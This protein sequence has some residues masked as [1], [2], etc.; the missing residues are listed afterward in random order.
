MEFPITSSPD[1][2]IRSLTTA[3]EVEAFFWLNARRSGPIT[4]PL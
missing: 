1:F 2:V 3:A 4:T